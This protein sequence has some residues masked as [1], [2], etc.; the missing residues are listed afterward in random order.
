MRVPRSFRDS[1]GVAAYETRESER[2][3]QARGAVK[4]GGREQVSDRIGVFPSDGALALCVRYSSRNLLCSYSVYL[5]S[6]ALCYTCA[7]KL[8]R[9]S[10]GTQ[11]AKQA[12]HS[13]RY[14]SRLLNGFAPQPSVCAC[15]E[16]ARPMA[17]IP[18]VQTM[19][20]QFIVNQ[21]H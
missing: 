2:W 7:D 11:S 16:L 4:A 17:H 13:G 21:K 3:N 14:N 1:G 10:P 15:F 18:R 20:M 5:I 8:R 12:P 19:R 9:K 6:N